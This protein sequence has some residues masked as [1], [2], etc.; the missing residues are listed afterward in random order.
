M[1]ENGGWYYFKTCLRSQLLKAVHTLKLNF[2]S[3]EWMNGW[4]G[5]TACLSA[6][7]SSNVHTLW[8]PLPLSHDSLRTNSPLAQP[9]VCSSSQLYC[10]LTAR[11]EPEIGHGGNIYTMDTGRCY[12]PG[13]SPWELAVK[14]P[15]HRCFLNP[16]SPTCFF[17][18][19]NSCMPLCLHP[20]PGTSLD[21]RK[22]L[23]YYCLKWARPVPKKLD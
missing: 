16:R 13:I 11:R 21:R 10:S 8:S 12:K 7:S 9:T 6:M 4:D 23:D 19:S 5:Y 3:A 20:N 2:L 17:C 14:I 1:G 15:V 18:Q 22:E